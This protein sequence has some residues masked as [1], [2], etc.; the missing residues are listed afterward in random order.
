[1][2]LEV[3]E[4][5]ICNCDYWLNS[6]AIMS[7]IEIEWT[8][9]VL[10][11][12]ERSDRGDDWNWHRWRKYVEERGKE[13]YCW[14]AGVISRNEGEEGEG[15]F[16]WAVSLYL[17]AHSFSRVTVV[18]EG[19]SVGEDRV[20]GHTFQ[21]NGTRIAEC[22]TTHNSSECC[23]FRQ[24]YSSVHSIITTSHDQF[25]WFFII[26]ETECIMTKSNGSQFR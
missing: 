8:A 9:S 4:M 26:L 13:R 17:K 19:I 25:T 1:M 21:N 12:G 15:L 16:V 23:E 10:I 24:V 18:R 7:A 3:D 5:D 20:N 14:R 11:W 6:S 2:L 22:P